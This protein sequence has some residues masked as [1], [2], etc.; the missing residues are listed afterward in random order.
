M[1]A[2][3]YDF[4]FDYCRSSDKKYGHIYNHFNFDGEGKRCNE[5]MINF[6]MKWAN[7]D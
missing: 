6:F 5:A 2:N 4:V 7:I 3:Q 1:I